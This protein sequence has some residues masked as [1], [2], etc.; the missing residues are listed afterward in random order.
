MARRAGDLTTQAQMLLVYAAIR[1]LSDGDIESMAQLVS[2]AFALAERSP[3]P[4]AFV[5]V[6][7]GTYVYYLRGES[8][9]AIAGLDRAIELT[10]GDPR[11]AADTTVANP[12]AYVLTFKGGF[13]AL[14]GRVA[15]GQALLDEGIEMALEYED[16]ET[17]GWGYQWKTWIDYF[18]CDAEAASTDAR[19]AHEFA[20]RVGH[21]FSR[22]WSLTMLGAVELIDG[23][24][25][26]ARVGLERAQEM[27]DRHRTAVE[28]NGLRSIW[29]GEAM[30]GMGDIGTA[31]RLVSEGLDYCER[32]Q[33]PANEAVGWL[34][35]ARIGL[36]TPGAVDA[37]TVRRHLA[38]AES[39]VKRT[40]GHLIE[41]L[42]H[43]ELAELARREGDK[44]G[45]ERELHRADQL[46]EEM[47]A[48][49][50]R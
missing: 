33:M 35:M 11:V 47:G 6:S 4:V 25:E 2:Q 28:G 19:R 46:R 3:D 50:A 26:R 14:S 20:E 7:G 32:R 34:A 44:E 21:N 48:A 45:R 13:M 40:G 1:G 9:R 8:D 24:W 39:L 10:G 16:F 42:L 27:A 38:R 5:S 23:N 31:T 43:A 17:A 41:P 36:A 37:S 18:T 15:E 49:P 29:R 22:T 12:L 30:R